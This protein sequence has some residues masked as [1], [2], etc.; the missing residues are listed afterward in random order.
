[1]YLI[2]IYDQMCMSAL[3]AET[4][5]QIRLKLEQNYSQ[6]NAWMEADMYL[7]G[8]QLVPPHRPAAHNMGHTEG[9]EHHSWTHNNTKND[10]E[11]DLALYSI[12]LS[13]MTAVCSMLG[14]LW[15]VSRLYKWHAQTHKSTPVAVVTM[16]G[17]TDS[18]HC[19]T[20]N[21]NATAAEK[22]AVMNVI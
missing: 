13:C 7:S 3:L 8:G 10:S 15:C 14:I 11:V 22:S 1:M 6:D 5:H 21:V 2:T 20:P 9:H 16:I 4:V 12:L 19:K 17:K 18:L